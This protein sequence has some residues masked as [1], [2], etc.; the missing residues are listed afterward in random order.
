[1]DSIA[2]RGGRVGAQIAKT[3]KTREKNAAL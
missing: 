3:T 2:E 1:L